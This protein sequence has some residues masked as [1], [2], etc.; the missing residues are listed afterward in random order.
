MNATFQAMTRVPTIGRFQVLLALVV[1]LCFGI[2]GD[3]PTQSPDHQS[4]VPEAF[5]PYDNISDNPDNPFDPLKAV[6]RGPMSEDEMGSVTLDITPVKSEDIDVLK[7]AYREHI[8]DCL[9]DR[10]FNEI[11]KSTGQSARGA[12]FLQNLIKTMD[13]DGDGKLSKTEKKAIKKFM[14]SSGMWDQIERRSN[15]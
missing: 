6:K 10:F 7:Q 2:H 14:K 3:E 8:E 1:G 5:V 4:T 13:A 11:T 12:P 9:I 15:F